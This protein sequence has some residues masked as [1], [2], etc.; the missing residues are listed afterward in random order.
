MTD[1][2]EYDHATHLIHWT[3]V[4][5]EAGC[6]DDVPQQLRRYKQVIIPNYTYLVLVELFYLLD[7][8]PVHTFCRNSSY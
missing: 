3:G 8:F 2:Q 4:L 6:Y 7:V 5:Q 1:S